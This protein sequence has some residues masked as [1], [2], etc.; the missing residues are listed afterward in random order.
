MDFNS[1]INEELKDLLVSFTAGVDGQIH[2]I[3]NDYFLH[4]PEQILEMIQVNQFAQNLPKELPF[5]LPAGY[6][7]SFYDQLKEKLLLVSA[8]E[9]IE[10]LSPLLAGLKNKST[11]ELPVNNYFDRLP[12]K[13]KDSK[14]EN[15]AITLPHPA[16][17]R[18]KWMRWVA[19]AAVLCIFSIGGISFFSRSNSSGISDQ[20]IQAALASIPDAAIQ[21]YL[22][23]NMDTYDLYSSISDK[24]INYQISPKEE[25]ML[26]TIS[27]DEIEKILESQI[28]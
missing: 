6:F 23:N 21:Q 4:F 28:N 7:D 8:Q 20:S 10:A 16:I 9:E 13:A 11:F 24:D 5:A 27:D 19:A 22:N 3:S 26:N 15:A 2:F 14:K 12:E 1:A 17:Q 18:I 25:K